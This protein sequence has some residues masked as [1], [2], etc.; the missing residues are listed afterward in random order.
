ML[1]LRSF[2]GS[3]TEAGLVEQ[4]PDEK[5]RTA[6][7]RYGLD[8]MFAPSSV[9]V[10]GATSRPGTVGRTVMENLL[11]GASKGKV[12]PVNPNHPEVLG[13]KT[14]SSIRDVPRPVDLAVIT[15]PATTVPQLVGEC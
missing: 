6:P 11:R 2:F 5:E 9:A 7:E 15:T 4:A 14:Y 12:Y 1:R 8:A 3:S 10:I 13:L